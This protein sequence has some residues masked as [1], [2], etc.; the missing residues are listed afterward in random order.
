MEYLSPVL[1][2]TA[3]IALWNTT[4]L[5]C[6]KKWK[7]LE[8]YQVRRRL[9]MPE[10]NCYLCLSFWI[11][12]VQIGC[13]YASGDIISLEFLIVPFCSCPI[14]NYLTNIAVIHDFSKGR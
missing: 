10:G 7:A 12:V 4:L 6:L 5:V 11:S 14:T 9:W 3:L 1:Q 2:L 13:M 8:W